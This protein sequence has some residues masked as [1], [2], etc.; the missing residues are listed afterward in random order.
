MARV[1]LLGAESTGKT[2]L[3]AALAEAYDTV[4]VPESRFI[5]TS[6]WPATL[7]M[8]TGVSELPVVI[9]LMLMTAGVLAATVTVA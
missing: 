7:L 3:A 5:V 8:L 9:D 1:C 2:T 4:W 6:I